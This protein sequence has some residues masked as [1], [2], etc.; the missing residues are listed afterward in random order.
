VL[1]IVVPFN[2]AGTVVTTTFVLGLNLVCNLV[3]I[4]T[5]GLDGA[6]LANLLAQLVLC[7]GIYRLAVAQSRRATTSPPPPPGKKDGSGEAD[8]ETEPAEVTAVPC[9]YQAELDPSAP[10]QR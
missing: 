3:L 9:A 10:E 6:A 7:A 4:P 1:P 8:L 5:V 2:R